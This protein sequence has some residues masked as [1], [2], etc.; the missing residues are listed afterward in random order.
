MNKKTTRLQ[1]TAEKFQI[2]LKTK[3]L[4]LLQKKANIL[5]AQ[6]VKMTP[7]IIPDG[8]VAPFGAKVG[9]GLVEIVNNIQNQLSHMDTT[10][11]QVLWG[12]VLIQGFAVLIG[13]QNIE[14]FTK[15]TQKINLA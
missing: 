12:I 11:T 8:R 2:L 7:K 4:I 10:S 13:A 15:F 3:N 6:L 9:Q 1:Q 5:T 14:R